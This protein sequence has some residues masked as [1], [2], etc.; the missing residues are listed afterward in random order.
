MKLIYVC[1]TFLYYCCLLLVT[2]YIL[3]CIPRRLYLFNSFL[4][5][6][7][8]IIFALPN[9]VAFFTPTYVI[10][11]FLQF[12]LIKISFIKV[13]IRYVI[14]LYILLYCSITL[15]TSLIAAIFPLYWSYAE[16]LI[17]IIATITCAILCLTKTRISTIIH[18]LPM[19]VVIK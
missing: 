14:F 8:L 3:N 17:I 1:E 16:T 6:I 12:L 7:P 2:R 9:N 4:L 19:I 10:F 5:F 11:I 13:R 15:M 18:T